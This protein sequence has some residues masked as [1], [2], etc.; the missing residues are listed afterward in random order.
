[1]NRGRMALHDSSGRIQNEQAAGVGNR[2]Q[3]QSRGRVI[4]RV[5][6]GVRKF[7]RRDLLAGF[8][9]LRLAARILT[10]W[11]HIQTQDPS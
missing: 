8:V 1:M 6:I 3:D 4:G 7:V 9:T 2:I 5:C 10:A 11:Q